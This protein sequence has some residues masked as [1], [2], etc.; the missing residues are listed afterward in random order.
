MDIRTMAAAAEVQRQLGEQA[1]RYALDPLSYSDRPS[2]G[3]R[4]QIDTCAFNGVGAAQ[5]AAPVN[6]LAVGLFGALSSGVHASRAFDSSS[7]GDSEGKA[8]HEGQTLMAWRCKLLAAGAHLD[9]A[10]T[11]AGADQTAFGL[12]VARAVLGQTE[13]SFLPTG[14]SDNPILAPCPLAVGLVHVEAGPLEGWSFLPTHDASGN[15]VLW[16]GAPGAFA[17]LSAPS[18]GGQQMESAGAAVA[19]GA[20]KEFVTLAAA[21][22]IWA[23]VHIEGLFA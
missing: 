8:R 22:S 5:T 15:P 6:G 18:R 14:A 9:S 13:I 17:Q 23:S 1:L 21:S 2:A 7:T 3:Q 12:Q 16:T 19:A 20:Y 4:R 10:I 11:V